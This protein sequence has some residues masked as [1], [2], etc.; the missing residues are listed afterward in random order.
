MHESWKAVLADEVSKP[1]FRELAQFV[2]AERMAHVVY[3]PAGQAFEA[4]KVTPFDRAKVLILGQDPYHNAGQAHGLCFSVP[5]G[6][7]PPPSLVNIFREL[8]DDVGFDPPG[9]GNLTHWAKQG[10]LLLNA[11]LTVRAH[12]AGSH[13]DRGWERFTDAVIE[14]LSSRQEPVVFVLWGR[15]ARAKRGLVEGPQH[16]VIEAPHPSPLSASSGFFGSR[17]FSQVNEALKRFGREPIDWQL[18]P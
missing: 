4:L 11:V 17:P 18:P 1:Y 7:P 5:L 13:R 15:Y 6:V 9:H 10:V 3:P 8:V 12:Q 2:K 16:V 14:A